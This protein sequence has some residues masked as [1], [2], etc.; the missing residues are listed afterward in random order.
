MANLS[1]L[2]QCNLFSSDISLSYL[3]EP[4]DL[5]F[6]IKEEIGPLIKDSDFEDMYKDGGRLPVSPRLLILVL[7]MQFLEGLSD[8][9]AVRNLKFRLDWKIAF[10]LA[11][12]FAGIHST[13][14]TYFRDRLI[15][16]DKATYTFDK[17]LEHLSSLGLIKSGGKQR[18]DSTHIIGF[19]RELSRIELLHETLRLFCLD[20]EIFKSQMDETLLTYQEKYIDKVSTYRMSDADK[21]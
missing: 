9:A 13:T 15:A 19:V 7:L 18:I 21:K 5:C 10:G 8:R 1:S 20:V 2:D 6:V 14:M 11:V 3:L 12:D 4:D 16:N 17:I